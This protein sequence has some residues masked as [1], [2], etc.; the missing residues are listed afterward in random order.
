MTFSS[1]IAIIGG[2]VTAGCAIAGAIAGI[3]AKRAQDARN[4]EMRRAEHEARLQRIREANNARYL[5]QPQ[6]QNMNQYPAYPAYQQPVNNEVHYY[7]HNIPM[8][9]Q[10][11]PN[12]VQN[13][14]MNQYSGYGGCNYA[15]GNRSRDDVYP[16]ERAIGNMSKMQLFQRFAPQQSTFQ[17][18]GYYNRPQYAYAS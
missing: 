4:E 7:Y 6:I 18:F 12:N 13:Q 1:I 3:R 10:Q 11:Y 8:P 17:S 9:M 15:Y 5:Q 2:I 16:G 14:Y